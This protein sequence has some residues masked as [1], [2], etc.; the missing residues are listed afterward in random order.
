MMSRTH[1]KQNPIHVG[2][3]ERNLLVAYKHQVNRPR[4]AVR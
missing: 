1:R 4:T 3:Q 2:E